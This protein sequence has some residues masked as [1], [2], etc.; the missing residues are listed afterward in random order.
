M[1]F[2]DPDPLA[3]KIGA[4]NTIDLTTGKGYNTDAG[5]VTG[6]LESAGVD[7]EGGR[8]LLLGAGGAARAAA[9]AAIEA[10]CKL[11][12]A[13][14]TRLKGERLADELG[15]GVVAIGLEDEE[16]GPAI[17]RS[18]ILINATSVGMCPEICQIPIEPELLHPE[19]VVFDLIYNPLK[20]VLL[21]EAKKR[22]CKTI[23]GVK[24]L[25]YQG[26]ASFKIW[27]GVNPPVEVMETAVIEV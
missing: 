11:V 14:R 22:G 9:F 4:V 10:G 2:V 3:K 19:L 24:M 23:S 5:G 7:F 27:L 17:A 25:V 13:N 12:I 26:A 16:I 20:T 8:V 18:N 6:S 1:E 21:N 15:K